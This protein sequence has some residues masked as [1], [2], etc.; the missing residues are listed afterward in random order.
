MANLQKIV[1]SISE[2]ADG[3]AG[4]AEATDEQAAAAEE[5]ASMIDDVVEQAETVSKEIAELA[6]AN[7]EQAAMVTEVEETVGQLTADGIST[8]GGQAAVTDDDSTEMPAEDVEIPEHLPDNMPDFVVDMLTEA[9][10]AEV[11]RGELDPS[12]LL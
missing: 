2:T 8:D 6:S 3:I 12:D 11:A 10:L 4:V 5:I 1:E 9:Q 7:E